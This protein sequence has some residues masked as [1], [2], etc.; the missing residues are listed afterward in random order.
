MLH[1]WFVLK[2]AN[3]PIIDQPSHY[4]GN[5]E[6]GHFSGQISP[7]GLHT[8]CKDRINILKRIIYCCDGHKSYY[9]AQFRCSDCSLYMADDCGLLPGS[10]NFEGQLCALCHDRMLFQRRES[11]VDLE[12]VDP[13]SAHFNAHTWI[14]LIRNIFLKIVWIIY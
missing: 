14:I 11:W 12:C 9:L 3:R 2:E 7:Q 13:L 4:E 5:H 8:D 10:V 6:T 1:Q